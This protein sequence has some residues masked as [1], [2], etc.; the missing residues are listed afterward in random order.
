MIRKQPNCRKNIDI[1]C[2]ELY[3]G[4]PLD[5]PADEDCDVAVDSVLAYHDGDYQTA[6]HGHP[7]DPALD[8]R[9]DATKYRASLTAKSVD[10]AATREVDSGFER[11]DGSVDWKC[12]AWFNFQTEMTIQVDRRVALE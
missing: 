5:V 10:D 3:D 8:D 6:L 11:L 9:D 12:S 7:D 4:A 1:R 2:G